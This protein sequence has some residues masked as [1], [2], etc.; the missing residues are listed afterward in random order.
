[1][2]DLFI[3]FREINNITFQSEEVSY[4]R[5]AT[6]FLKSTSFSLPRICRKKTGSPRF[7]LMRFTQRELS[8]TTETGQGFPN[9]CA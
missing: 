5:F 6:L 7:D 9:D 2:V 8:V 1:M 3:G 4:L